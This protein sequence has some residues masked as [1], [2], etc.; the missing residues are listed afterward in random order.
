MHPL[1]TWSQNTEGEVDGQLIA[2]LVTTVLKAV[3]PR[4][5]KRRTAH[6]ALVNRRWT[7]NI[8]GALKFSR[9]HR[10]PSPAEIIE[11]Y[12]CLRESIHII[13]WQLSASGQYIQ[14]AKSAYSAC[15]AGIVR[16]RTV[17]LHLCMVD[18]GPTD[19]EQPTVSSAEVYRTLMHKLSV[20]K[21]MK[22]SRKSSWVVSSPDKCGNQVLAKFSL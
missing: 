14:I 17:A 22:Q 13:I 11:S 3:G 6:E 1:I 10:I 19:V 7:G 18:D 5:A 21:L 4:S 16:I 8:A 2:G 12:V 20:V 15:F 9:S